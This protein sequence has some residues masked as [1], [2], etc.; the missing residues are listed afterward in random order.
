M[1]SSVPLVVGLFGAFAAVPSAGALAQASV[2]ITVFESG[3][4]GVVV[5][6]GVANVC[7]E[8][9]NN[10]VP[11]EAGCG[12]ASVLD[13]EIELLDEDA[14]PDFV[15][16]NFPFAVDQLPLEVD[17]RVGT[18]ECGLFTAPPDIE[19]SPDAP[20]AIPASPS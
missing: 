15:A 20:G 18:E 1:R 9:G 5:Y 19:I 16:E 13:D 14:K 8:T 6:S 12:A 17:F 3:D 2:D 7:D 11:V 10:C 4:T